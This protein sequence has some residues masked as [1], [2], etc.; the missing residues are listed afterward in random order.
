MSSSF[1]AKFSK[2]TSNNSLGV[3]TREA[4]DLANELHMR[5]FVIYFPDTDEFDYT[6]VKPDPSATVM[7]V[8]RPTFSADDWD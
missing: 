2:P 4:Q 1:F 8:V 5:V 3:T 6:E 7:R